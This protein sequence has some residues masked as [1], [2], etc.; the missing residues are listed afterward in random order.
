M[1]DADSTVSEGGGEGNNRERVKMLETENNFHHYFL[2]DNVE[3]E[4]TLATAGCSLNYV[5]Y[6]FFYLS[7][8]N[9]SGSGQYS[10]SR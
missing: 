2:E 5:L 10:G 3:V 8:S 7:G 9:F 6:I 1:A 4:W